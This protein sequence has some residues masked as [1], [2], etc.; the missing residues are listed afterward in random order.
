MP[1]VIEP[2]SLEKKQ[3]LSKRIVT[4]SKTIRNLIWSL[5]NQYPK[6][7]VLSFY[8]SFW[9]HLPKRKYLSHLHNQQTWWYTVRL[10]DSITNW[11]NYTTVEYFD[12]NKI[13]LFL[14]ILLVLLFF[15]PFCFLR[16]SAHSHRISGVERVH[17]LLQNFKSFGNL[18]E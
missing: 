8:L 7:A 9:S 6:R 2:A 3:I 12:T 17:R 15:L 16:R 11:I 4:S 10:C 18:N 14:K 13:I 5:M 1:R